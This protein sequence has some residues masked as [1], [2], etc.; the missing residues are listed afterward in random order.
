MRNQLIELVDWLTTKGLAF[1]YS[2]TIC[3]LFIVG[4]WGIFGHSSVEQTLAGIVSVI[5]IMPVYR[6]ML[7]LN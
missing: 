5:S 3:G 2:L 1:L 4:A 7:A 6:A